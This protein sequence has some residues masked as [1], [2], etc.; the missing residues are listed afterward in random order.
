MHEVIG[1][2]PIVPTTKPDIRAHI[3]PFRHTRAAVTYVCV[4]SLALAF[5]SARSATLLSG[6]GQA[7]N[8]GAYRALS[9]Y[10]GGGHVRLCTLPCP[11]IRKCTLC[12]P[13]VGFGQ[14]VMSAHIAP[15]VILGRRSRTFVYA[16]LPSHSKVHVLQP[17]CRVCGKYTFRP[18][19]VALSTRKAR[20]FGS[21]PH[22]R[23]AIGSPYGDR[24]RFARSDKCVLSSENLAVSLRVSLIEVYAHRG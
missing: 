15:F 23:V 19:G 7:C 2:S 14:G 20:L 21:E 6:L 10:S 4:R 16:P 18:S 9:S 12:N 13:S 22:F 24:F 17:F 8:G 1:S 5:E 11:R 3:A